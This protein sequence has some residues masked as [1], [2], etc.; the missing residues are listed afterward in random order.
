[1]K[2]A[3][4]LAKIETDELYIT[5]DFE[6]AIDYAEK[7]YTINEAWKKQCLILVKAFAVKSEAR[8]EK[9]IKSLNELCCEEESIYAG[10]IKEL[11]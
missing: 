11:R 6:S 4:E 1:M 3:R 2:I 8:V 9:V 7:V 10:I 5:D